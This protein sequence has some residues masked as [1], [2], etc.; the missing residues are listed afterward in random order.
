MKPD[1]ITPVKWVSV[2][3]NIKANS[4]KLVTRVKL[5]ANS[6][7]VM[8]ILPSSPRIKPLTTFCA[9]LAPRKRK[10]CSAK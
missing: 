10:A 8:T 7:T 1:I 6:V 3:P 9:F 5:S 4:F 2:K